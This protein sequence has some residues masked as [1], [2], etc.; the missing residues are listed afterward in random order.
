LRAENSFR[1]SIRYVCGEATS[2]KFWL[3]L[4]L[5]EV[6]LSLAFLTLFSIALGAN[7]LA[8]SQIRVKMV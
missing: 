7:Y 1:Q 5:G 2:I 3:D 8:F 4:W 6:P